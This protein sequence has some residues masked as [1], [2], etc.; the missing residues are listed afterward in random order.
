[1]K[2]KAQPKVAPRTVP[3]LG[4]R[5]LLLRRA[6]G[7]STPVLATKLAE[8]GCRIGQ[9]KITSLET[10]NPRRSGISLS[11]IQALADVLDTSTDYLLGRTPDPT[12]R[13]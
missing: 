13:R 3:G 12:P 4:A 9:P 1:M 5:I 10:D 11:T 2:R 6:R 8:H 7:W